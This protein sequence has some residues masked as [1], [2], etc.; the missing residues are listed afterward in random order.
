MMIYT[1]KTDEK[2]L[3]WKIEIL[4][5]LEEGCRKHPAYRARRAVTQRFQECVFVWNA[6]LEL[7]GMSNQ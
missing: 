6:R 1:S 5:I 4:R 2:Q 7:N 3:N